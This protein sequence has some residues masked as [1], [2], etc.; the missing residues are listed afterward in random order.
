M[1]LHWVPLHKP[2][3]AN[4]LRSSEEDRIGASNSFK[5]AT[6]TNPGLSNHGPLGSEML[7]GFKLLWKQVSPFRALFKLGVQ[8]SRNW[9]FFLLSAVFPSGDNAF[10]LRWPRR[11]NWLSSCNCRVFPCIKKYQEELAASSYIGCHKILPKLRSRGNWRV[12]RAGLRQHG[13]ECGGE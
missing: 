10:R 8:G 11:V 13:L 2:I 5:I 9:T 6:S 7:T 4:D 12:S 1:N 3:L